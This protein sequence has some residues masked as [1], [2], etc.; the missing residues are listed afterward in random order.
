MEEQIREQLAEIKQNLAELKSDAS[1]HATQE[2]LKK[3]YT[4][5]DID[6]K[7]YIS[8][9]PK[10]YVQDHELETIMENWDAQLNLES[11]ATKD[12]VNQQID[13]IEFPTYT[14]P[15]VE[16]NVSYASQVSGD[17]T[18]VLGI[19]T[20]GSNQYPIVGLKFTESGGGTGGGEIE[21][22][23]PE[24]AIST[25]FIF[26]ANN[27]INRKYEGIPT[28]WSTN[29]ASVTTRPV[30]MS[31]ARQKGEEYLYW[32]NDYIW[33]EP[34]QII[35][36]N[37]VPESKPSSPNTVVLTEDE[38][39]ELKRSGTLTPNTLYIIKDNDG[40]ILYMVTTDSDGNVLTTVKILTP[41][42]QS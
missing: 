36:A 40:N 24:P 8:A 35:A 34:V 23:E 5:A 9:I 37:I 19:L 32:D 39:N 10:E 42:A 15:T 11:Y 25:I 3:Y 18:Y 13:N 26:S 29:I 21:I 7:Q 22:P 27:T 1:T 30:Y 4:K 17:N 28:G 12:Y 16:A 33:T 14:P 38:F 2:D 6:K 31:T 41:Q 20:S